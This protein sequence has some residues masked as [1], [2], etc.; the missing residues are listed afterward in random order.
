MQQLDL[1][2]F[3][4][5]AV[6]VIVIILLVWSVTS[7]RKHQ[8]QLQSQI[9]TSDVV[10]SQLQA[11]MTQLHQ[12]TSQQHEQLQQEIIELDQVSKQLE[13]RIKNTNEQNKQLSELINQ[14]Q[15]QQPE[16]RLYSRAS[17]LVA[18]GADID[19]VMRECDIPRAEAELLISIHKKQ[20]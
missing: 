7:L 16:N 8:K 20:N 12:A 19:E 13:I 3:A 5:L 14:I 9:E 6:V 15:S 1:L 17:K 18:L 4:A 11:Q 2:L 10:C